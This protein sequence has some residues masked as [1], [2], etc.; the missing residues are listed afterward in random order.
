[1]YNSSYIYSCATGFVSNI[2]KTR[3]GKFTILIKDD[4]FKKLVP[5]EDVS[6]PIVEVHEYVELNQLIGFK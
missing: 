2:Y 1:M 4:I 3:K 6:I 5:I